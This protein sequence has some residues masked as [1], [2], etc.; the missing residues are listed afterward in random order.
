MPTSKGWE[1]EVE[2]LAPETPVAPAGSS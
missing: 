2:P 1:V